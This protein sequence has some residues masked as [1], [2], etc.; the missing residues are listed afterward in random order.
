MCVCV[1][2]ARPSIVDFTLNVMKTSTFF[3]RFSL[4]LLLSLV[5]IVCYFTDEFL[6]ESGKNTFIQRL[7]ILYRRFCTVAPLHTKLKIKSLNVFLFSSFGF[8]PQW[9]AENVREIS[10]WNVKSTALIIAQK[11]TTNSNNFISFRNQCW[12]STG[13][14]KR[15]FVVLR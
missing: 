8:F 2:E 6:F 10:K 13:M 15:Y 11:K 5:S 7:R 12:K 9:K 3:V 14:T 4:S 1:C